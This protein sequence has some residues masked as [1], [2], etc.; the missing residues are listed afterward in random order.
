MGTVQGRARGG[1]GGIIDS[2]PSQL[3]CNDASTDRTGICGFADPMA[4]THRGVGPKLRHQRSIFGQRRPCRG[5]NYLD[6][7]RNRVVQ[8]TAAAA[9]SRTRVDAPRVAAA[10]TAKTFRLGAGRHTFVRPICASLRWRHQRSRAGLGR[11]LLAPGRR[12]RD[13]ASGPG[14][15]VVAIQETSRSIANGFVRPLRI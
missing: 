5:G 6:V 2:R 1:N 11:Q 9:A 13:R 10:S 14:Q 8:V 3:A 7:R 15:M 4:C 12:F